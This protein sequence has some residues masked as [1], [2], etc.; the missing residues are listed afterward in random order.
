MIKELQLRNYSPQTARN[1]ISVLSSF[2]AQA[3]GD[4]R[5]KNRLDIE[6]YLL[7]LRRKRN[8]CA[9]TVNLH[10]DGLSFF[11]NQVIHRS[12]AVE[13]IPRLK[14][15]HKL[16][17]VLDSS[18]IE[19]LLDGTGNLKHRLALALAYGCGLRLNELAHLKLSDVQNARGII[20]IRK[21]KG[22]KDRIVT[23]PSSLEPM[24]G[25][26]AQTYRPETYFFEGKE[27]GKRLSARTF[28]AV[29][30]HAKRKSGL[31]FPGGIHS[32][33]HS[34]ATHLLEQGTDLRS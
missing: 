1:Y 8:L 11:F 2:L 27:P 30:E 20:L 28:Q 19:A 3:P 29:F 31:K 15:D 21:G 34:F 32:L 6:S 12:G 14:E 17:K 9:A 26:Y 13:K 4:P 7:M 25:L 24:I 23:L 22:S 10:R 18:E 16:P 5:R 33:R